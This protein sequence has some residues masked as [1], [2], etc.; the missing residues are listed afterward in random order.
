MLRSL[1]EFRV[2]GVQTNIPFLIN[3]IAHPAFLDSKCTTRFIDETP[4]LFE[5]PVRQDRASRL[6]R[7]I[8]ELIVN[9]H[10]E[11]GSKK[12]P[13][14]LKPSSPSAP[15]LGVDESVSPPNGSRTRFLQVGADAFAR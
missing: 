6:L 10:P 12:H 3:L 13:A 11:I 1:Q 7:Y 14:G 2:R 5:F 4:E 8:G 9:G 15:P